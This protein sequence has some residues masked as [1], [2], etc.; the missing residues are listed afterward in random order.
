MTNLEMQRRLRG[1]SQ[2]AL[3]TK[4]AFTQPMISYVEAGRFTPD[5][6]SPALK[7]ALEEEF[8]KPIE[9][10]LTEVAEGGNYAVS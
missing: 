9:W 6:I 1:W 8:E 3:A 5:N 10:L 4:L 7:H 2:E